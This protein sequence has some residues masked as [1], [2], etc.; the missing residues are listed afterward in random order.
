MLNEALMSITD[1]VCCS[2]L[3]PPLLHTPPV[4]PSLTLICDLLINSELLMGW[5]F[6][7]GTVLLLLTSVGSS[8]TKPM[9]GSPGFRQERHKQISE[10][11]KYAACPEGITQ[12]AA[13]RTEYSFAARARTKADFFPFMVWANPVG[14]K[15]FSYASKFP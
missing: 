5:A 12:G 8:T 11:V 3:H 9:D 10:H 4:G 15:H 2:L 13:A 1:W 7:C 6:I 14:Q